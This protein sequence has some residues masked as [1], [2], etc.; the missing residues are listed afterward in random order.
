MVG[1]YTEVLL[2]FSIQSL[3]LT[4]GLGVIGC[5]QIGHELEQDVEVFHEGRDELRTT[6]RDDLLQSPMEFEGM[7]MIDLGN[8]E[9]SDSVLYREYVDHLG[10]AVDDVEDGILP[11][12]LWEWTNDVDGNF[13]PQR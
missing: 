8:A 9:S 10:E 11:I 3:G 1:V 13:L 12:G 7:V 6:V 5:G 4:I 2:N